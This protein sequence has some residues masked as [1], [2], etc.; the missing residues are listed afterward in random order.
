[1]VGVLVYGVCNLPWWYCLP[2]RVLLLI[3]LI[4]SCCWCVSVVLG[5][6]LR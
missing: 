2:F 6:R 5:I 3:T 1:M 4:V